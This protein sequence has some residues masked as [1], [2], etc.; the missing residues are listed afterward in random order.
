MIKI[1]N[2]YVKI[3]KEVTESYKIKREK[4]TEEENE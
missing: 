4:L 3:D 2:L 1:D